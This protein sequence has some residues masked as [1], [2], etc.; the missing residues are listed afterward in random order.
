MRSFATFAVCVALLVTLSIAFS[1]NG[2]LRHALDDGTKHPHAD[3]NVRDLKALVD[4]IDAQLG[5]IDPTAGPEEIADKIRIIRRDIE[6]TME[7]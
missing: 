6:I 3:L 2:P 7:Y 1:S 5:Q 4:G